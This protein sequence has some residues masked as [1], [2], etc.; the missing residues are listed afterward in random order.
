MHV[1]NNDFKLYYYQWN[2]AGKRFIYW[3]GIE[4]RMCLTET[5]LIKEFLSKYSTISGKS[6]QQQQ[7]SK[8]F[9]G[10]GL[11]MAN[12]E[13]WHHQRHLVSPAFMGEKL[14]VLKNRGKCIR[15][16]WDIP[17]LTQSCIGDCWI[18]IRHFTK[19][20]DF[21]LFLKIRCT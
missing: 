1:L 7:G 2:F 6:S 18:Y 12:G 3:N 16:S 5:A 11:L 4:P 14:K 20:V 13:D 15:C 8:H 19:Y 17:A 9:I 10:K 21:I